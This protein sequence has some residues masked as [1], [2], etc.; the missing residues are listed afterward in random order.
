MEA[1]K[2]QNPVCHPSRKT[3][4]FLRLVAGS[5][6]GGRLPFGVLCKL[7]SPSSLPVCHPL[8]GGTGELRP[9][10]QSATFATPVGWRSGRLAELSAW[11]AA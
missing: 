11:R 5:P 3:G 7:L 10:R 9:L 8:F 1:S 4:S 6:V 2:G